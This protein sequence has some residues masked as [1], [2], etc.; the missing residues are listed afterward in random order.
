MS[1]PASDTPET[2]TNT[3]AHAETHTQT[4]VANTASKPG[5]A[6]SVLVVLLLLLTIAAVAA[7]GYWGWQQLQSMQQAQT[8]LQLQLKSQTQELQSTLQQQQ[9]TSNDSANE[10]QPLLA[11]LEQRLANNAS[12]LRN[13]EATDRHDWLLAEAE[14]LLRLA[15]QRMLM[16]RGTEGA[17]VL[18]QNVDALLRDM[19]N[20]ELFAVRQQ[21]ARDITAVKLA[22]V[23][24]RSGLYL[25]L[26]ALVESVETLSD[27]PSDLTIA[28]EP[29]PVAEAMLNESEQQSGVWQQL[30]NHFWS[31]MSSV[32]QH[33]RV[34]HHD[35]PIVPVLP[36][37]SSAYVRQNIRLILERAQLAML[38]ENTD[39]YQHSI[40]EARKV[41]LRY[42][43]T[44]ERGQIIAAE[45][46][47]LAQINV[48]TQLPD[49]GGSLSALR[50][51]TDRLHKLAPQG[52]EQAQ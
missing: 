6:G 27:L 31:A 8:Q 45:L 25:Q 51:Y 28:A 22:P 29:V 24:D 48:R 43:A 14:Y 20:D 37:K 40:Q 11:G 9:S 34:R 33:I 10:L 41:L 13:L 50:E 32:G 39:I 26:A 18:M 44:Q 7:G 15:N 16:E 30:Q 47:T 19:D 38:R 17:L 1:T 36:P 12:R 5:R 21:L 4:T 42:F 52:Q 35:Q 23:V 2:N 49:I 46:E 3:D